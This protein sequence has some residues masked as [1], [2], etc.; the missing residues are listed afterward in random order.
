M[1]TEYVLKG[2]D[3]KCCGD[4]KNFKPDSNVPIMGTCFE[5]E[6]LS[7]GSCNKFCKKE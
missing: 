7:D 6:V 3:G 4:C 5:V 1:E 2:Q